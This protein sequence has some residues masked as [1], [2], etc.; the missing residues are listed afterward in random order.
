MAFLLFWWASSKFECVHSIVH[1]GTGL[2]TFVSLNYTSL[3]LI[4]AFN[5]SLTI[6]GELFFRDGWWLESL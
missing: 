6:T 5:R 3:L 2:L 1:L 4:I